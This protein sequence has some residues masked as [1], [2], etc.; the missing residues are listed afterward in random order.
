MTAGGG[1]TFSFI[2]FTKFQQFELVYIQFDTSFKN[3][4]QNW[5][6]VYFDS[7]HTFNKK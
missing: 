6:S 2:N 3:F 4:L 7:S 1:D 5:F